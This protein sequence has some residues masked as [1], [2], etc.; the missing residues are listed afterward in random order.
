MQHL[1]WYLM[2]SCHCLPCIVQDFDSGWFPMFAQGDLASYE[3]VTH[4]LGTYPVKI[5]VLMRAVDGNNQRFVFEAAGNQQTNDYSC[6]WQSRALT[7]SLFISQS[8]DPSVFR[9]LP[10]QGCPRTRMCSLDPSA[11]PNVQLCPTAVS[12]LRTMTWRCACGPRTSATGTTTG[13]TAAAA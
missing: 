1:V 7:V 3:S 13:C 9:A 5:K 11:S 6:K 8:Q 10:R 4:N 12:P 2:P